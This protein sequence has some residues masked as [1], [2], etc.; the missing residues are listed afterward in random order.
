MSKIVNSLNSINSY[1]KKIIVVASI[2]SLILCVAGTCV[3][4]FNS[5]D[6][7]SIHKIGSSMIYT[8]ITLFVELI[9][10]SLVI[11]FF[12]AIIENNDN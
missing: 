7:L 10:G 4:A 5:N 9:I 11:D 1:S 8:S 6:S 12:R 3:I 2:L